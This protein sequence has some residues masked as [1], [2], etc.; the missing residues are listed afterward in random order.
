MLRNLA[1]SLVNSEKGYIVTTV[2]KAKELRPF[3]EKVITLARRA[4]NL[5]GDEAKAQEV[6]LR[7]QAARFFHA[8]NSTFKEQQSR[9][10]G[11]KGETKEPIERTAGVK[12][13]QTLFG[14]LGTRY[15]SR[16]GGYT[17]IIKLGR[18]KGD[19][20]EMAVIELVDNPREM[21][22]KK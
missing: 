8:G 1:T 17:R 16:N 12:A 13:V 21:A 9:F 7:R 19:N 11:K 22:A 18:R 4:K 3:V 10:R 20:A 6:H 14:D 5:T 2:P 15:Q